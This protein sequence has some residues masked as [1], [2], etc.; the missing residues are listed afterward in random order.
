M[1]ARFHIQRLPSMDSFYANTVMMSKI[2]W[3]SGGTDT[4]PLRFG[5]PPRKTVRVQQAWFNSKVRQ[6]HY[7]ADAGKR[8]DIFVQCRII[9]SLARSHKKASEWLS[10][11]IHSVSHHSGRGPN[12]RPTFAHKL[13]LLLFPILTNMIMN[14]GGGDLIPAICSLKLPTFLYIPVG[15]HHT[16]HVM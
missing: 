14:V 7:T 5:G 2:R 3:W 12:K 13:N 1:L 10:F 8:K 15:D 9:P 4:N 6:W 11:N 16:S